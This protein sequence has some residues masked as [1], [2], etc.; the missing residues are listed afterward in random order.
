MSVYY[1]FVDVY[2]WRTSSL[3]HCGI[4]LLTRLFAGTSAFSLWRVAT[5]AVPGLVGLVALEGL[6][7]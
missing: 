6:L 5:P 1:V 7:L 3:R 4:L 2:Y